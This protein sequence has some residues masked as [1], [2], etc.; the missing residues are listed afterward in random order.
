[1]WRLLKAYVGGSGNRTPPN[2]VPG[3]NWFIRLL[4]CAAKL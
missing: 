2:S 3:G 4:S 1:M